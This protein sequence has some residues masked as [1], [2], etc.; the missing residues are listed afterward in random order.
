MTYDI[1]DGIPDPH[2]PFLTAAEQEGLLYVWQGATFVNRLPQSTVWG[3]FNRIVDANA[4][5]DRALTRTGR[6]VGYTP[7]MEKRATI[8]MDASNVVSDERKTPEARW[9]G[10]TAFETSR[11]H[12]VND[13]F[14]A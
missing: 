14:F 12:Q 7:T 10:P 3:I 1:K 5:F 13:P 2:K 6:V 9:T 4:A 11:L 8:T